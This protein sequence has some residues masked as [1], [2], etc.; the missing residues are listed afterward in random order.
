MEGQ[1]A[2]FPDIPGYQLQEKL[3]E[4]GM[5]TVYRAIQL[6]LRRPVAV[7]LL[8]PLPGGQLPVRALRRESH[9]MGSLSH[10][11]VVAV[12]DCG[13]VGGR[14]YLVME[15]VDGPNL[16]VLLLPGQPWPVG[17]A[18]TLLD[19]IAQALAYIHAQGI[20]HL[21]LKPENVL[22]SGGWRVEGGGFVPSTLLPPPST[23][24]I[25]DFGLALPHVDAS[26]LSELGLARGSLDYCSPEQRYGLPADVRADLFSLATLAYE[27]LTGRLPGRVFVPATQRNARLPP[28]VDEVLRRGLARDPDDRCRT[29]AAFRTDLIHAL[30]P[31]PPE[32]SFAREVGPTA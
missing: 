12:H 18:L 2:Y 27:I 21:D 26:T 8:H 1:P 31:L 25:T 4:G 20:L 6:S 3:G 23:P 24:K 11:G 29:V 16:R 17:R 15:Y 14:P 5:G 28:A 19:H 10:P 22:L 32:G 9:L 13:E 30:G 7:K